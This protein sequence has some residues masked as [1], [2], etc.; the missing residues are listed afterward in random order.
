MA[1]LSHR[2]LGAALACMIAPAAGAISLGQ[3]D[4]FQDGTTQGWV[5]GTSNPNPPINVT[6]A[7]PAGVGDHALQVTANGTGGAG[8]KLVVFNE[9]QW[10]GDYNAQGITAIRFDANNVGSNNVSLGFSINS[11]S[12]LTADTGT[13]TPGSGWNTYQIPLDTLLIGSATELDNVTE[14]RL[15]YMQGGSFISGVPAQVHLDNIRA[16]PE[17]TSLALIGLAGLLVARRRRP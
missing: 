10:L 13:I 8:G 12:A 11:G 2:F 7:G 16:V 15:R 17:P 4:D 1:Y 14:I 9:L 3:V 6:D 5:S